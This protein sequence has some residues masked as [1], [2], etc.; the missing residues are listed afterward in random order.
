MKIA[1][2]Q[3]M[4]DYLTGPRESFRKGGS[5]TTPKRGLVDEPGSYAG[6]EQYKNPK[7]ALRRKNLYIQTYGQKSF[8]NLSK[9][10]KSKV[11]SGD[12][13]PLNVGQGKF[14]SFDPKFEPY[15]KEALKVFEKFKKSKKPFAPIDVT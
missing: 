15:R 5:V 8:D 7:R 14:K 9:G 10:D 6:K 1:E 11:T 12:R 13:N 4:M 3:Q 2:Y